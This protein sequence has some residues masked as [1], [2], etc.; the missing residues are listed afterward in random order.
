DVESLQHRRSDLEDE[1]LVAMEAL[2][3]EADEVSELAGQ[4]DR[5]RAEADGLREAIAAEEAVIDAE[6]AAEEEARATVAA[7][8]PAALLA[9]YDRLRAKLGGVGAARLVGNSCSWCHLSLPA[10]ERGRL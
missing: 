3:P 6:V 4:L 10:P 1:A 5:H 9:T 7:G 8:V 2:E